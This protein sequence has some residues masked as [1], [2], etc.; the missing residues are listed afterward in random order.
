MDFSQCAHCGR[1]IEGTGIQFR[2]KAFC[3]DE[4]CEEFDT[5]FAARGVPKLDELDDA[6][7]EDTDFEDEDDFAI[8]PDDF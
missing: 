3:G 1:E 7:A 5:E 8:E 4:C 6:E 2:G